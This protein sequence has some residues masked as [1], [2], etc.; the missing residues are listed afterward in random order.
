MC[1]I[2][3]VV[4]FATGADFT[5]LAERLDVS[6]AHRGPDDRGV[7]VAPS[8]AALL[9]H[10]RLS[11]ID[12]TPAGRQPMSSPDGRFH[13]VFNGEVYNHRAL[14]ASLESTGEAFH[15]QSDT[16]ILLRL[17]MRRGPAAL[18]D[19]RGMFALALWDDLAKTMTVARDRFGIKP[20]YVSVTPS[21]LA[22]ASEVRALIDA[23]LCDARVDPAG[24]LAFL[25]WGHVPAPLTW[26]HGVAA[27]PAGEWARWHANG[28]TDRG[29]FADV[30][31]YW[32]GG[33][34]PIDQ[35]AFVQATR[36][37]LDESVAAHLVADVPVGVFLSGGL[38]SAAL[39]AL[40]RPH[41][42][43]LHTYTVVVDE[44]EFSEA[45]AAEAVARHFDTTHHTLHIDAA[46]VA[47]DVDVTLAAMDQPTVDGFN[48]FAVA[49]AVARSGVKA[50]LSGI[51][52]DELFGGYPSFRRLPTAARFASALP[53]AVPLAAHVAARSSPRWQLPRWRHFAAHTD[54]MGEMY[55]ALRGFVMPAELSSLIG[56][57]LR[58]DVSAWERVEAV[59]RAAL[60]AV[61][62]ESY[63]GTTARLESTVYLRSQLLRDTDALSMAHALE[64]R[65][66]FIDAS[67][68]AAVWPAVARQPELLK[69][70]A[71]LANAVP[72][73]PA[74]IV[75]Q[76]KRGFTLPF[77][78]WIDAEL[79]DVVRSGLHVLAEE[80]WI[81]ADAPTRLLA[82][83]SAR[84]IH[85][86]RVWGLGILGHFLHQR[87]EA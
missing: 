80:R 65:V 68:I 12:P 62:G 77:E 7:Y 45:A 81:A 49:G 75:G 2:A 58:D 41:V 6:L 40:A 83:W 70:K 50:V 59:E 78:M 3:G 28:S 84:R 19:I 33:T 71:L 79:R 20:L 9:V 26:A 43:D 17:L 56:A 11:I 38:D 30:S 27:L 35:P 15:T 31:H 54:S 36:A 46:T 29:Q 5:R 14:R 61:D 37:A 53:P 63:V 21:R 47:R 85:W 69:R 64:V 34:P 25:R 52:G 48:T 60:R 87:Q 51:G 86:G 42:R 82:D 10:R 1:G 16:E 18:A 39:T 8:G 74:A 55:R 73:L 23:D 32:A 4:Q 66:P 72:E 13:L 24:V 57:Q 76:P 22:F 67:L 44:P